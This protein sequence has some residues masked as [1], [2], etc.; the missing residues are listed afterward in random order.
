MLCLNLVRRSNQFFS[1]N[2]FLILVSWYIHLRKIPQHQDIFSRK[3]EFC[4]PGGTVWYWEVMSMPQ[5]WEMQMHLG[6]TKE[7]HSL[8]HLTVLN[9][10]VKKK[11]IR[12][13]LGC[14]IYEK[15]HLNHIIDHS[16]SQPFPLHWFHWNGANKC[17]LKAWG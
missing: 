5:I 16:Y 3:S 13:C 14:R 2:F 10:A 15:G 4:G 17:I 7:L 6:V 1:W 12:D 11:Q 9:A 8:I